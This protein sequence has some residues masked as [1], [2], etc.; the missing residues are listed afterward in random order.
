MDDLRPHKTQKGY[1]G[2]CLH[3]SFVYMYVD[4]EAF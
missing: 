2:M 4:D 3:S 1:A